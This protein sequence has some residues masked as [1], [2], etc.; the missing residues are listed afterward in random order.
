MT[1]RGLIVVASITILFAVALPFA[2]SVG[3]ERISLA[4]VLS[5]ETGARL[6]FGV[7]FPRVM[8][9]ALVGAILAMSGA[10][11]QTLLRNPLAD[12]FVLGV[13]GGAACAAAL[14][15]LWNPA[16]PVMTTLA[17]FM[18]A[19]VATIAVFLLA[20][21]H[22]EIEI[23]RMIVAGLVLNSL[24][25]AAILL[26]LST[27]TS[28]DLSVALRWMSGLIPVSGWRSVAVL[29]AVAAAGWVIL[30]AIAPD[31][32][33][34]D[35]GEEDA[36]ARGV[37]VRRVRGISFGVAS[38]MTGAAVAMSGVIG[39]VGLLVPYV[40]RSLTRGD[41]RLVLPGSMVGGAL[42]LVTADAFARTIA[43]PVELPVG[44]LLAF[45]GAPFF[46]IVLRRR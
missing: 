42:L 30:Q 12:P 37:D 28:G 13:S 34:L 2:L 38:L 10:T 35:F 3:A 39:F 23:G 20:R 5:G 40:V 33:M 6:I 18:G 11:Y 21:R 24:F 15:T 27:M 32:R 29:A 43:A 46:I 17:A 8:V 45:L 22:G 25:S 16:G 9:A 14:V 44:A 4:E 19:A 26:A 31:L 41:F 36:A 7:R 1:R